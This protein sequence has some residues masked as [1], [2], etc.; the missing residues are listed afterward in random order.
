MVVVARAGHALNGNKRCILL[1]H[2]N[3][4]S[5]RDNGY[6]RLAIISVLI[7]RIFIRIIKMLS[8]QN[9]KSIKRSVYEFWSNTITS[10][11]HLHNIVKSEKEIGHQLADYVDGKT[12]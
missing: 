2:Y 6:A 10:D 5:Y 7:A 1:L 11:K 3:I 12:T 4:M 9:I 8:E